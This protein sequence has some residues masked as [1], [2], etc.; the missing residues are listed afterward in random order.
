ML[1]RYP[2]TNKQM[3]NMKHCK[4]VVWYTE[5]QKSENSTIRTTSSEMVLKIIINIV[6]FT[7]NFWK[8]I[9]NYSVRYNKQYIF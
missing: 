9:P 2:I 3:E 5:K 4:N 8:C 7:V 1:I 6:L